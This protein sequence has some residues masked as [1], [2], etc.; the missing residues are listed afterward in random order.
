MIAGL[1]GPPLVGHANKDGGFGDLGLL[2]V[3]RLG[4]EGPT[5]L[6]N[7]VGAVLG[8]VGVSSRFGLVT[9]GLGTP[10]FRLTRGC[11]ATGSGFLGLGGDVFGSL[12]VRVGRG[13]GRLFS[14]TLGDLGRRKLV[15][16][17]R[18]C[19]VR[20]GLL[21]GEFTATTRAGLVGG[22][23]G[24]RLGRLTGRCK[25]PTSGIGCFMVTIGGSGRGFCGQI[26]RALLGGCSFDYLDCH[27]YVRLAG[28]LG[29]RG[30]LAVRRGKRLVSRFAAGLGSCFV[31]GFGGP[32]GDR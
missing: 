12:M 6:D 27:C 20:P 2:L 5:R 8:R 11:L 24:R 28:R 9:S 23:R 19:F 31:I 10:G 3:S 22:V 25:L 30:R 15:G 14:S 17:R 13:L 26:G 32:S 21:T 7:S 4:F 16:F 18:N 29:P 1:G